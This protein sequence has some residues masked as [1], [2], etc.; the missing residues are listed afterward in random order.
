MPLLRWVRASITNSIASLHPDWSRSGIGSET[1]ICDLK[2]SRSEASRP[3]IGSARLPR[4]M[5]GKCPLGSGHEK[6]AAAH[7]AR[8]NVHHRQ[9]T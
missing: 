5:F 7:T 8:V 6:A 4:T 1:V 2:M 9:T 3:L